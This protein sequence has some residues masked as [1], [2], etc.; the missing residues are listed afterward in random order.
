M[1]K[2]QAK[3]IVDAIDVIMGTKES[4]ETLAQM[5]AEM[6]EAFGGLRA[7]VK[8]WAAMQSELMRRVTAI[9]NKEPVA[10]EWLRKEVITQAREI[11]DLRRAANIEGE[12]PA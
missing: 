9:E 12:R 11:Q 10:P 6:T 7:E 1:N 4:T 8:Q 5:R 3:Q 2:Q